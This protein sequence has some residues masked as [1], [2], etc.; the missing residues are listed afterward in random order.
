MVIKVNKRE[1]KKPDQKK[2]RERKKYALIKA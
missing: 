1:K 2:K